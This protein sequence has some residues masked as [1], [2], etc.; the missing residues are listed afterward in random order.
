MLSAPTVF[1]DEPVGLALSSVIKGQVVVTAGTGEPYLQD[2]LDLQPAALIVRSSIRNVTALLTEVTLD[3]RQSIYMGPY[4]QLTL[5]PCER[6]VLQHISLGLCYKD[7][8]KRLGKS[9]KTVQI[10]ASALFKKL[11]VD[12]R[13]M[14]AK[15]YWGSQRD[16]FVGLDNL[17]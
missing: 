16:N 12:N 3:V 15:E 10:Q 13:E 11:G 9:P 4:F 5:T 17:L 6:R 2:I 7:I 1:F 8:A 14:A